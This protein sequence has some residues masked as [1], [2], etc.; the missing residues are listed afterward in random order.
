M[1]SNVGAP[2]VTIWELR[3]RIMLMRLPLPNGKIMRLQLYAF[4]YDL[5]SEK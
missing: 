4:P 2:I 5:Y 3:S 1:T